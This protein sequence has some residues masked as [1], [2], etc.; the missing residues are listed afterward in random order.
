MKCSRP[1]SAAAGRPILLRRPT[2]YG[3]FK[4]KPPSPSSA[5]SRFG[6]AVASGGDTLVVGAYED[7]VNGSYSGS[8]YVFE[9]SGGSWSQQAKLDPDDGDGGDYFGCAV[10]LSGDTLVVGAYLDEDPNGDRA[11][12]VYVFEKGSGWADGGANQVSV[13]VR[14]SRDGASVGTGVPASSGGLSDLGDWAQDLAGAS[15]P[16]APQIISAQF[17]EAGDYEPACYTVLEWRD[18][19]DNE[20]GFKVYRW[21]MARDEFVSVATLA[22]NDGF[23]IVQY[24]DT[25]TT[26]DY[27][28]SAGPNW[29]YVVA[30]NG[31][32]EAASNYVT[33]EV[34]PACVGVGWW[35]L[36]GAE[37]EFVG[38]IVDKQYEKFYYYLSL[39]DSPWFR[40][41]DS[42]DEF[43]PVE[44]GPIEDDLFGMGESGDSYYH[45]NLFDYL[46]GWNSLVIYP[47]SHEPFSLGVE[48]FGWRDGRLHNLGTYAKNHPYET[49]DDEAATAWLEEAHGP[50]GW[51]AF[52]YATRQAVVYHNEETPTLFD[53]TLPAPTDL[54]IVPEDCAWWHDSC[55]IR[56][57]WGGDSRTMD[58]FQVE[59]ED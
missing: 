37:I 25:T 11:G 32:G 24:T 58:G 53:Y 48:C 56:W 55:S 15:P 31:G 23:D 45:V 16:A 57:R 18:R 34:P 38:M 3:E 52:W 28:V 36:T 41:P 12:S 4:L 47:E 17:Y 2:R 59:D 42:Q 19:S 49:W 8:V 54:R 51:F 21:D 50:D 14:V 5:G 13:D 43:M 46:G 6:A 27:G 35:G 29:Y 40:A 9:R 44:Y 22:P 30:Y 39:D 7:A 10:A 26:P 20:S 33:V 1:S